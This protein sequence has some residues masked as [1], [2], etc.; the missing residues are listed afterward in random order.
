MLSCD[1]LSGHV[2]PVFVLR[3]RPHLP[4]PLPGFDPHLFP[5]FTLFVSLIGTSCVL[6]IPLVQFP[7]CYLSSVCPL[8]H[9]GSSYWHGE[10]SV[11]I[12]CVLSCFPA[13]PCFLYC[14]FASVRFISFLFVFA[15]DLLCV[16]LVN[17]SCILPYQIGRASC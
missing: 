13:L 17:K 8:F 4:L 11:P 16:N 1:C 7:L 12:S 3:L 2:F 9:V 5:I 14:C 15:L 10:S 6:L